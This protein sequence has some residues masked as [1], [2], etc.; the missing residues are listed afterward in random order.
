MP[1]TYQWARKPRFGGPQIAN[2]DTNFAA[3]FSDELAGVRIVVDKPTDQT[4]EYRWE[5]RVRAGGGSSH[6]HVHA[7]WRYFYDTGEQ[8]WRLQAA[9]RIALF[10]FWFDFGSVP[11]GSTMTLENYLDVELSYD[12]GVLSESYARTTEA[13]FEE[14]ID[15][16]TTA[17]GIGQTAGIIGVG[18]F[19]FRTISIQNLEVVEPVTDLG[20]D[21]NT[22]NVK[23]DI[24][25]L[26]APNGATL[27]PSGWAPTGT[28]NVVVSAKN[29]R[30]T[31]SF[32]TT[33]GTTSYTTSP[34]T[35]GKIASF[36]LEDAGFNGV[37]NGKDANCIFHVN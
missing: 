30:R 11:G 8:R 26:P 13:H 4:K 17:G 27:F 5:V 37:W 7:E 1:A 22:I 34:A 2:K 31:L 36:D 35:D 19:D 15:G 25:T 21:K 9:D 12:D 28:M 14:K 33:L 3:Y 24:H 6:K 29:L 20:S 16:V 32:W 18:G 10:S 23:G